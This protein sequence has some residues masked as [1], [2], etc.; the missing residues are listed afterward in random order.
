MLHTNFRESAFYVSW[1]KSCGPVPMGQAPREDRAHRGVLSGKER[2]TSAGGP[3]AIGTGI[4]AKRAGEKLATPR[5]STVRKLV[6][7]LG[8]DD[9]RELLKED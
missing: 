9:P 8:I 2:G 5:P 3:W 4:G 7:A 1:Q 6:N